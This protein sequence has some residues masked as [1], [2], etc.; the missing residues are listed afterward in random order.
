MHVSFASDLP[1]R[2]CEATLRG[3]SAGVAP[4]LWPCWRGREREQQQQAE[5]TE[6]GSEVEQVEEEQEQRVAAAIKR[7]V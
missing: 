1:R 2:Q 6:R 4:G 7:R 5:Q 3:D